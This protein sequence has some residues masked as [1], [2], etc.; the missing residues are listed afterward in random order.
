MLAIFRDFVSFLA[1]AA[2]GSDCLVGI[3][4]MFKMNIG[5]IVTILKISIVLYT[6]FRCVMNLKTIHYNSVKHSQILFKCDNMFQSKKV[7]HQAKITK[8][9]KM[10]Y[11]IEQLCPLCG[12]RYDLQKCYHREFVKKFII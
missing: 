9:F 6:K 1:C 5:K 7:H 8:T 4:H 12:I 11:D 3:L 10:S 2:Y